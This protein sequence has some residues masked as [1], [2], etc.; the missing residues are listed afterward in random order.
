MTGTPDTACTRTRPSAT[1]PH[2]RNRAAPPPPRRLRPGGAGRFT[3]TFPW[4]T[5]ANVAPPGRFGIP[6]PIQRLNNQPV[7]SANA[8]LTGQS[9]NNVPV[10]AYATIVRVTDG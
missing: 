8:R 7:I 3:V 6:G 10:T 4:V 1:T 2:S 5:C 9:A